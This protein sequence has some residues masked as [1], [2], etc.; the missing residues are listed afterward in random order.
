[1]TVAGRRP[2][3]R[4]VSEEA[5]AAARVVLGLTIAV[6]GMASAMG[7]T[8]GDALMAVAIPTLVAI[9][10]VLRHSPTVAGWA[11]AGMWLLL[12]PHAHGEALLA[13]LTMAVLCVAIA[14]GPDRFAG[15]IGRDF[16][17][18]RAR[19][20]QDGWIEEDGRPLE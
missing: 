11:G 7:A 3:R 13:P 20:R 15:W 6:G 2:A 9:L 18:G 12:L 14:V 17:G 4:R 10:G 8:T 16:A 1:M 19:R 5:V